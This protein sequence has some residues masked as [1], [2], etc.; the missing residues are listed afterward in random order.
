MTSRYNVRKL[1]SQFTIN[2]VVGV[3]LVRHRHTLETLTLLRHWHTLE[4][5]THSWDTDRLLRHWHTLDSLQTQ[6]GVLCVMYVC[7]VWVCVVECVCSW[8]GVICRRF[9]LTE[10]TD[11]SR[12]WSQTNFVE[13]WS[14]SAEM[15]I[16]IWVMC[17]LAEKF[18]WFPRFDETSRFESLCRYLEI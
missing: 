6:V 17:Q 10:C 9:P 13:L 7:H 4:T 8:V 18:F 11:Y 12:G 14:V 3:T 15:A 2:C 16:E 5:L 1:E